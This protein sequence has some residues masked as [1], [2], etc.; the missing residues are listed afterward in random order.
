MDVDGMLA[1]AGDMGL[2]QF[3]TMALFG[4]INVLSAFHYFA[5][6]LIGIE[7][8]HWCK[9]SGLQCTEPNLNG[10]MQACSSGWLYNLTGGFSTVVSEVAICM[11]IYI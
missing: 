9:G 5:Q 3:L 6:T 11:S 10:G 7:P 1:L 8:A 4:V 2:Y